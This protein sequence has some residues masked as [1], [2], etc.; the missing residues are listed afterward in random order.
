MRRFSVLFLITGCAVQGQTDIQIQAA[1]GSLADTEAPAPVAIEAD[2]LDD[3]DAAADTLE[4]GPDGELITEP[5]FY[6]MSLDRHHGQP[7]DTFV[8]ACE[9]RYPEDSHRRRRR[10][11]QH[12]H[13]TVLRRGH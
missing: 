6:N 1:E 10:Q 13:D 5:G 9:Q 3:V 12:S 7:C 2:G 11:R 4:F 8:R